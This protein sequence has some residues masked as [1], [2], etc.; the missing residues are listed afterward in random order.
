MERVITCVKNVLNDTHCTCETSF[1]VTLHKVVC[2]T[3]H[4]YIKIIN[5]LTAERPEK[6]EETKLLWKR[7]SKRNQNDLALGKL[8][9]D[10]KTI[11][12]RFNLRVQ[13]IHKNPTQ[14]VIPSR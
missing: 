7:I 2:E 1:F 6:I 3:Q 9:Q 5:I 10:L 11:K 8:R 4:E 14:T 13:V 12:V